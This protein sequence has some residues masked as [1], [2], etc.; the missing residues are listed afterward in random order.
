MAAV[1]AL[2]LAKLRHHLAPSL[3]DVGGDGL[4]LCLKAKAGSTLAIG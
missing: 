2:H 3:T 4:A 1:A